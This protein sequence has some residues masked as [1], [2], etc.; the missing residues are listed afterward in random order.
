MA[1]TVTSVG[2]RLGRAILV[3]LS[4]QRAAFGVAD[5]DIPR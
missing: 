4:V 5:Q 2:L 1:T 3:R